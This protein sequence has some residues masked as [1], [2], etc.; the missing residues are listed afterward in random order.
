MLKNV[1]FSTSIILMATSAVI[2][3]GKSCSWCGFEKKFR[4]RY[5]AFAFSF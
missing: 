2:A 1:S 4:V 3:G 5:T